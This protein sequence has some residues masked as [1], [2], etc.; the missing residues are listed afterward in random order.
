M[1]EIVCDENRELVVKVSTGL[2]TCLKSD[3][4]LVLLDRGIVTYPE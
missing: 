2:P 3:T 1:G 4:A